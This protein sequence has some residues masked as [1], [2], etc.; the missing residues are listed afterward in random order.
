MKRNST[1]QELDES[2]DDDENENEDEVSS[3]S[4]EDF[5]FWNKPSTPKK[6]EPKRLS[7]EE[8]E[9]QQV[10][11][12]QKHLQR[13]RTPSVESV[14]S[15]KKKSD[16]EIS[17]EINLTNLYDE[18]EN[19]H[20]KKSSSQD[21]LEVIDDFLKEKEVSEELVEKLN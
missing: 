12:L 4:K 14:E 21:D 17:L 8:W 6:E 15:V 13:V 5:S 16:D 2:S 7:H 20:L 19:E 3:G 10:L 11:F 18:N 1:I 9:E